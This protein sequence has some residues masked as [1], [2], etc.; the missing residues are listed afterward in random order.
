[1]MKNI[2]MIILKA[3][4]IGWWKTSVDIICLN[5]IGR[6]VLLYAFRTINF[7]ILKRFCTIRKWLFFLLFLIKRMSQGNDDVSMWCGNLPWLTMKRKREHTL[8]WFFEIEKYV[9][10]VRR[11][12]SSLI[13]RYNNA[14]CLYSFITYL[15]LLY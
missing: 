12:K 9:I 7:H 11:R 6:K 3:L 5:I 13:E 1:M 14:R 15:W 4:R 10:D 8:I 2:P